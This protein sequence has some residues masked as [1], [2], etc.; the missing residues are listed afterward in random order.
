MSKEFW[1]RC[2]NCRRG[3]NV[4]AD[5]ILQLA[6]VFKP[7]LFPWQIPKMHPREHRHRC[8]FCGFVSVLI[9]ATAA[10]SPLDDSWRDVIV[11]MTE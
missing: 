6:V 11:K 5:E 8:R 2:E 1:L 3:V 7:S 9:P 4:Q 10:E